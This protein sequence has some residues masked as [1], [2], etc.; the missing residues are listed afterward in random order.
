[1]PEDAQAVLDFWFLPAGDEGH[2][3]A[4]REWFR[5]DAQFDAQ[6]R[7]RFEGMIED[8][9]AGRLQAWADAG[10]GAALAHIVLLDQFTRN[11]WR[12]TPRAYAGDALALGTARR[13]VDSGADL[14]LAPQQRAFVYMPFEHAEDGATQRLSVALF[15]RL[16]ADAPDLGNLAGALDFARRHG[17]IIER[18]GRFPHRNAILGRVST[19]E[20]LAFLRQAGSGF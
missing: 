4:R 16:V 14:T 7:A 9:L 12:G 18:F 3:G 13:L 11:A 20:E 6:I 1:M 19:P 17:V 15:T 5:K 8:G 10:A 2:G